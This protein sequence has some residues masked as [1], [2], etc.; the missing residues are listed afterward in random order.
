MAELQEKPALVERPEVNTKVDHTVPQDFVY[1]DGVEETQ[2]TFRAVLIGC[3]LGAVVA[4]SNMFLGL[5]T[6]FTF[7]AALFGAIGGFAILKPLSHTGL[8]LFKG[9][10]GPKENCTVQTA[11]TAAGGLGIIFVSAIPAL[12][13]L[14][15]MSATPGDDAGRLILLT[16]ISAYYGLFF[17][18]PLRKYFVIK[19]KLVFPSPTASAYTIRSLHSL[20]G[21][22]EGMQKA[23]VMLGSFA[24]AIVWVV[25]QYF[26][27]GIFKDWHIFYWLYSWGYKS[28]IQA[29]NWGWV[30]EWTP[31]FIGAGMLSGLNVSASMWLGSFLAW[32]VIGPILVESGRAVGRQS[33]DHPDSYSYMAASPKDPINAPSPR[34]WLLWPGIVLMV[35][36]SFA[37]LGWNW[38]MIAK[39]LKGAAIEVYYTV[40]RKDQ[41]M[42]TQIDDED[43]TLPHEN[44]PTWAWTGGVL[45]SAIFTIVVLSVSFDIG[46]GEG[47][48]SIILAFFFS[49]IGLQAAGQT[50]IN[51]VSAVAK[52]S[53]LVFGGVTKGQGLT[54]VDTLPGAQRMNIIG[55]SV[56]AAAAAQS[57]DMVGDLKTGYLLRATPKGQFIA[58]A[59]GAFV[60]IFLSVGLFILYAKAYHCIV[61]TPEW[62]EANPDANCPFSLPSVFSWKAVAEALTKKENQIPFSSAM[63]CVGSAIFAIAMVILRHIVPERVAGW[64]PNSNAIGIAFILNTT[65]YSNAMLMGAVIFKVWERKWPS[66]FELFGV[67]VASG[68]IAGEGIGG[69]VQAILQ[70]SEV[71]QATAATAAWCPWGELC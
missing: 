51:P 54:T 63:M 12:Y 53:Q 42:I 14:D 52:T 3:I 10:F 32:G 16:L 39:G 26:A 40:T 57:V 64:V 50:D 71:D 49:F 24:F 18:I 23:Y 68:F 35:V 30:L 60:S 36:T 7:G 17:A 33:E 65:V 4:A 43:P 15:V 5:K 55:G 21:G 9:Y 19:Q 13:K 1:E 44:V 6:G 11:A 48:L 62:D 37:E 66:G 45:L 61:S 41:S 38:K 46:V 67:A 25:V 28:A 56:A 22:A 69:L 59:L 34:Y 70:I 58:Q 27:P 8:P 20:K 2:V 31:A 47:I 29:E